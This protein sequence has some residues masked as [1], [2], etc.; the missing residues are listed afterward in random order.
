MWLFGALQFG[1]N[2][3]WVFLITLLP[4]YLNKVFGVPLEERG[5]MQTVVLITGCC[6][7]FFGGFV[8]DALRRRLGPRLG[9][10]VPI[11]ISLSGRAGL[12]PRP[13]PADRLGHRGV[14]RR[15]G[16]PG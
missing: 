8:T 14:A 15:H 2:L 1:V 11:A 13:E 12:L 3:G 6:G 7:M 9:R 10:T 16:I 4:T 5:R